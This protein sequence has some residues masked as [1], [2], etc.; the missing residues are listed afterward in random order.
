MIDHTCHADCTGKEKI[1]DVK[2]E[3]EKFDFQEATNLFKILSEENRAKII[4]SLL[5]ADEL[6]VYDLANITGMTTA[7]TSHH[8][9]ALHAQGIVK[10]RKE[11]RLS[12]YSMNDHRIKSIF[13][14]VFALEIGEDLYV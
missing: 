3:L 13:M 5:N 4:F 6:C 1:D 12:H 11:G 7:N 9:R 2:T 14:E 10:F 8:L